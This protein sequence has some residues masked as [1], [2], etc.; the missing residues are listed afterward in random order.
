MSLVDPDAV[1]LNDPDTYRDG[2][3]HALF[4]TLRAR[5]PL[6]WRRE[7]DG[8]GY[9]AVLAHAEAVTVLRRT[10]LFSSW[11]GGIMLTDPPP[12]FLARMRESMLNRDPPAHTRLRRLVSH[13]F[14]PKR[15]ATL[16]ASVAARV[17]ALV[18]TFAD[19]GRC[20]FVKDLA[21]ELP[22]F[23]IC[24]ILGVPLADR[25]HLY[26]LTAR[27]FDN[28]MEDRQSEHRERSLA[29][30]EMR[31]YGAALA[32]EKRARPGDDLMSDLATLE[33]D[34]GRLDAAELE[35]F[36]MLL[37]NAGADTTR[38]ALSVGMEIM[39]ERPDIMRLL[40]DD[41]EV[42]PTAIDELVRYEPP[43]VQFR[44]TATQQVELGGQT[45]EEDQKV[46]VFFAAANRDPAVFRDPEVFDPWRAPNPHLAFGIG[47]H[48]CLGAPLARMEM[49]HLLSAV[50][51]SYRD[52]ERDGPLV[53][54]RSVFVR[55]MKSLR[56]RFTRAT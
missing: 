37:F 50:L 23:V 32:Q 10:D 33:L 6:C 40:R 5:S 9:W 27:M 2:I 19:Q 29:A 3:P 28:V 36:F 56:I 17:S 7:P 13:A 31:T 47:V 54:E 26:Q 8:P 43:T 22:L 15:I 16:E 46:V 44:R 25:H 34:G 30:K 45:I 53:R 39:L 42:M 11:R 35:A 55:S 41:P 14:T 18:G 38:T 21:G 1:D 49:R 52:I 24:E 12:E 51:R 4:A 20:D 48:Y